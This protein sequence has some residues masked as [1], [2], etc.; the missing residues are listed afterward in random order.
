MVQVKKKKASEQSELASSLP[1]LVTFVTTD[2]AFFC[3]TDEQA[4][5]TAVGSFWERIV[6]LFDERLVSDV[7]IVV[8]QSD[9]LALMTWPSEA[10]GI[11]PPTAKNERDAE[12]AMDVDQGDVLDSSRNS[13]RRLAH[14][15]AV[16]KCV[17]SI[18]IELE[19]RR[20]AHEEKTLQSANGNDS[21]ISLTFSVI[22]HSPVGYK[23]LSRAWVRD[24]II[25]RPF[26]CRLQVDLPELLD[27]SQC[28]I[29]LEATYKMLP[30]P[31]DSAQSKLFWNDLQLLEQS[32]LKVVQVVPLASVDA[33]LL[34][35]LPISVRTGLETNLFQFQ[36]MEILT[37]SVFRLL[38]QREVA[39]LIQVSSCAAP[40]NQDC[41]AS[42]IFHKQEQT[43]LLMA[44][45]LP[46]T[47]TMPPDSG[48]LYRYAH[49]NDLWEEFTQIQPLPLLDPEMKQQY[50]AYVES[51]LDLLENKAVNPLDPRLA[52]DQLQPLS[53][54]TTPANSTMVP[55]PLSSL[56]S[57]AKSDIL[58]RTATTPC[59]MT[60]TAAIISETRT[61]RF[62]GCQVAKQTS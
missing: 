39:L 33:C 60:G 12:N 48:L 19:T 37:R 6:R 58:A 22:D 20:R 35:G 25:G 32:K 28:S 15:I 30:C 40:A 13:S 17:R 7:Q 61:S 52:F 26:K 51:A 24:L 31:I 2:L 38:Q 29:S 59:E 56:P 53:S 9:K 11:G 21:A 42:Y 10:D 55:P 23:Y 45:E 8:G 27:G 34:F 43:F 47:H 44:Q 4:H 62:W 3:D 16:A 50:G 41:G 14:K 18:Q 49:A 1:T 54:M 5:K 46:K 36:E 57:L